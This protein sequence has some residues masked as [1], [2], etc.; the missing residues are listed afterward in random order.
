MALLPMEFREVHASLL[1][2]KILDELGC[3]SH[4]A[5]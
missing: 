1:E 3:F 4:Q 5:R 2:I